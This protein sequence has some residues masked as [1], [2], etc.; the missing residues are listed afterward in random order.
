M[1]M[2]KRLLV[3][4]FAFVLVAVLA[5][6]GGVDVMTNTTTADPNADAGD[7]AYESCIIRDGEVFAYN[8]KGERLTYDEEFLEYKEN[9]YY[10]INNMVVYNRFVLDGAIYDFGSEGKMAVGASNGFTYGEDGKLV[11]SELFVPVGDDVYYVINNVIVYNQIVAG[12][13]IYDFGSDGKMFK[14]EKDGLTYGEDGKLVANEEFVTVNGDIYYL[15][16]NIIIFNQFVIDGSIYDFGSD[17]K[18]VVGEKGEFTY[19]E[20]GKLI[21][22]DIFVTVAGDVYYVVNN[23]IVCNQ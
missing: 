23:V 22:S 1:K 17:G 11:G 18:M 15:V 6:C 8:A 14:G 12:D 7:K 2:A 19:G 16:N 3:L 9:T 21:G 13:G 5:S 10:V 4:V 20:D